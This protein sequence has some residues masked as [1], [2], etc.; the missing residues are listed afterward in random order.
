MKPAQ[1]VCDHV[2][3][4]MIKITMQNYNGRKINYEYLCLEMKN[5]PTKQVLFLRFCFMCLGIRR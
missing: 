2:S 4:L 1:P 3:K 5:L